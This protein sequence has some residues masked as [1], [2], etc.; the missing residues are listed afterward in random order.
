MGVISAKQSRNK[1]AFRYLKN[2]KSIKNKHSQFNVEFI[3]T[4]VL[5][6]KFKQAFVFSENTWKE[7]ELFFETDLLLGLDSFLKEDY[8]RAERYF[9]RLNKISEYNIYF[10]NFFGNVLMAWTKALQGNEVESYKFLKKIPKTYNHLKNTQN[11][12]LQFP[13]PPRPRLRNI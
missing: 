5:L 12:F 1:D 6:G 7:N 2:A 13:P 8:I 4:N 9:E 3:R 11:I 10:D